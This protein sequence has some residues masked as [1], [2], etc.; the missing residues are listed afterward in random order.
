MTSW[1]R[2]DDMMT[3]YD[4]D[5]PCFTLTLCHCHFVVFAV[6]VVPR[7]GQL[8][9]LGLVRG[10]PPSSLKFID[11][12]KPCYSRRHFGHFG[13]KIVTI[14]RKMTK[15][16]HF[17]YLGPATWQTIFR[18]ILTFNVWPFSCAMYTRIIGIVPYTRTLKIIFIDS[19]Y[20]VHMY[21]K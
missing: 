1:W 6:C 14:W 10:L 18:K 7:G 20:I 2:H 12:T 8:S 19:I 4:D 15:L 13:I 5:V 21:Y 3:S 16:R 9:V 17:E 11:S